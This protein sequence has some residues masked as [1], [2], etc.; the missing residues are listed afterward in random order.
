MGGDQAED[1]P[2]AE[3]VPAG[4]PVGADAV[5]D[6][7]DPGHEQ[8]QDEDAVPAEEA[9]EVGAGREE[10][11]EPGGGP[12]LEA[13]EEADGPGTGDDPGPQPLGGEPEGGDGRG[14]RGRRGAAEGARGT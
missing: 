12:G 10:D 8:Q 2:A 7:R 9:G 11:V 5:L 13:P 3:G 4:E 14:G 6:G 1:V